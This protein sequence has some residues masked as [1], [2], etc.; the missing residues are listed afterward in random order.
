MSDQ[1]LQQAGGQ[2]ANLSSGE[3][4]GQTPGNTQQGSSQA[5]PQYL[6]K[7]EAMRLIE[8]VTK[9]AQS[10]VDK[11][12]ARI[13]QRIAE[14]RA[15]LGT[16]TPD[17]E[18]NLRAKLA[19]EEPTQSPAQDANAQPG[20]AA[21]TSEATTPAQDAAFAVM[22]KKGVI[23]GDDDPELK[24]IDVSNPTVEQVEKAIAAKVKRL[25]NPADPARAPLGGGNMPAASAPKT[26]R[27]MIAEGL[28]QK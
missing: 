9:K 2:P 19:A 8:D 10:L 22:E 4:S 7:D 14:V 5:E 12:S 16:L 13:D 24:L 25:S 21:P 18:T 20:Q 26:P 23:I 6:T 28:K 1:V 3:G 27:Q 15:Q 17:Q 11:S